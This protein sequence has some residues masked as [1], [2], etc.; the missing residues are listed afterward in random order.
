MIRA[1]DIFNELGRVLNSLFDLKGLHRV[2]AERVQKVTFKD[3]NEW[4]K[5]LP[6]ISLELV[7]Y[8]T[9]VISQ[10]IVQ[11][12]VT[13]DIIYFSKG[14]TVA[15]ALEVSDA[16]VNAFGLGLHVK[17]RYLHTKGAPDIHLEGQDLHFLL[18]FSFKDEY[19]PLMVDD[20]G[21]VRSY[22]TDTTNVIPGITHT[23]ED[24]KEVEGG[25]EEAPDREEDTDLVDIL[26]GKKV[27]KERV[28]VMKELFQVYEAK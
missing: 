27:E 21:N 12:N 28:E 18:T 9:P 22:D 13:V 16:L 14:N 6:L 24:Q 23:E 1:K 7:S 11:K 8:E 26:P 3:S 17:D 2:T 4:K 15:E 25:G 20:G 19:K 10:A 5:A